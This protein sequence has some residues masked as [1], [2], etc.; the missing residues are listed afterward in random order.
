MKESRDW[1]HYLQHPPEMVVLSRPVHGTYVSR[2]TFMMP[3][4]W[5]LHFYEYNGLLEVDGVAF[6]LTPGSLTLVPPGATVTY[7]YEGR[8]QHLYCHFRTAGA[9]PAPQPPALRLAPSREVE[10]LR[11]LL[12]EAAGF[13]LQEPRRANARLWDV[14]LGLC[15]LQRRATA[16]SA[17]GE[18]MVTQ[19]MQLFVERM[20]DAPGIAEIA[21]QCGVSHNQFIRIIRSHCGQTPREWLMRMRMDRARELLAY[22][23]LPVKVVA[24]EVGI[25]DLQHFNKTI[26][27]YFGCSPRQLRERVLQAGGKSVPSMR[28]LFLSN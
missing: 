15:A 3:D 19:A 21:R 23:D 2:E 26:H 20:D 5:A 12:A 11:Q 28:D 17:G 8:S 1:T 6:D 4:L 18:D 13:R 10:R 25:P 24:C 14:L 27:R 16:D 9:I 7:V 22:Y